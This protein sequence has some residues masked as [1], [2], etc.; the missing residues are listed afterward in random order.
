MKSAKL[1]QV[2]Q[3]R[4]DYALKHADASN[5]FI[6]EIDNMGCSPS[7]NLKKP[8]IIKNC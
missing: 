5:V 7:F 4:V 8:F 2:I 1:T 3:K 6:R